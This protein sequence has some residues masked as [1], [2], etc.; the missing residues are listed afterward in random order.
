M[1]KQCCDYLQQH[2]LTIAFIESASSG[3]LSS[4]FSIYKNSGAN[5]LLGGLVSYDPSIKINI[6]KI[7]PFLIKNYSA[8]SAQ[9]TDAMAI[10]GKKL[11]SQA[12]VIVACTGLLK[13][14]GSES[15]EKPEGTFFITILYQQHIHSFRYF[16]AGSVLDRLNQ[17]TEYV[18]QD[19]LNVISNSS[20]FN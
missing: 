4:Q 2:Q 5:I 15:I 6:L 13:S 7:D 20:D 10:Q 1:L 16:I 11:F 18:A 19:L 3:Y 14:G 12:D 8:E 9:V 17:L